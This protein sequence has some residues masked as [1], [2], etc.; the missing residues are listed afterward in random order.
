MFRRLPALALVSLVVAIPAGAETFRGQARVIDALTLEVAGAVL[1]LQGIAAPSPGAPC[2][3]RGVT[4]DCG[5]LAATQLMDLTFGAE[6]AC[7]PLA[8]AAKGPRPARCAAAGY[9]LATGMVHSGWARALPGAAPALR[10]TEARARA[11]RRGLWR[12]GF[13]VTVSATAGD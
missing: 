8:T 11:A 2:E 5:A 10:E 6:I 13:P 4:R 3:M 12:E 7:T 1:Q 9:D